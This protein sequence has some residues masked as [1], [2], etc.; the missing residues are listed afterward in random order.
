MVIVENTVWF[1]TFIVIA[2][3]LRSSSPLCHAL[4]SI[5]SGYESKISLEILVLFTFLLRKF[6]ISQNIYI[7]QQLYK[8][9]HI[10]DFCF[11]AFASLN[12]IIF[13]IEIILFYLK[14]YFY[15]FFQFKE[16][17]LNTKYTICVF[18]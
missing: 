8:V 18:F 11:I 2:C 3:S 16:T 15:F 6:Q 5:K 13:I 7:H 1:A 9:I 17:L 4:L 12:S 10:L 14:N